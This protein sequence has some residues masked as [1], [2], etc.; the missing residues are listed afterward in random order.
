MKQTLSVF[1]TLVVLSLATSGWAAELPP[2]HQAIFTCDLP[3]IQQLLA[4]K[5]DLSVTDME[6]DTPL[7]FALKIAMVFGIFDPETIAEEEPELACEP[8]KAK[9]IVRRLLDAGADPF[10]FDAGAADALSRGIMARDP[11]IVQWFLA[12]GADVH[13]PAGGGNTALA[14]AVAAGSRPVMKLILAK[15]P[16]VNQTDGDR[17][18]PLHLALMWPRYEVVPLLVEKGAAVNA[19]DSHGQTPLDV[20]ADD[21]PVRLRV[22]LE[23]RGAKPGAKL[24]PLDWS[25]HEAVRKKDLAAVRAALARG[26]DVNQPDKDGDVVLCDAALA[27]DRAILE[28]LLKAGAKANRYCHDNL[29]LGYAYGRCDPE[30]AKMLIA[31]GARVNA[32]D[33]H[34]RQALHHA[35]RAAGVA[36]LEDLLT[37]GAAV[38]A[39]AD[40]G[41]TPLLLALQWGNAAAVRFLLDRGAN[42]AVVNK[43]GESA[44]GLAAKIGDLPLIELLLAKGAPINVGARPP[45]AMAAEEGW[46]EAMTF[47]LDRG[48]VVD[49]PPGCVLMSAMFARKNQTAVV[50]LLLARGAPVNC[51]NRDGSTPLHRAAK[52]HDVTLAELLLKHGA[53]VNA[54]NQRGRTPLHE[55]AD[56]ILA[57]VKLLVEHGA[58]VNV[59]DKSG[60]TPLNLAGVYGRDNDIF[61]YLESVGAKRGYDLRQPK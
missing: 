43:N 57:M 23:K 1:L 58:E 8:E 15:D 30:I 16:D 28:A 61:R 10:L 52:L 14:S 59:M 6:G 35:A 3:A 40:D 12:K 9:A 55:A 2:L 25:L 56:G 33:G 5:T 4:A 18:T 44:V 50:Q 11:E 7:L 46:L 41:D 53:K 31:A 29:P 38:D 47:L 54:A 36:A 27:G 21:A 32:L 60:N 37:A 26:V 34:G 20:L 39:K 13:R 45:L 49:S 42:P 22:L 24:P 48:A 17:R 19:R 51:G